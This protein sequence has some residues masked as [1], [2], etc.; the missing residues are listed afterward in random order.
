[1]NNKKSLISMLL[2]FAMVLTPFVGLMPGASAD[3]PPAGAVSTQA[4]LVA[5]IGSGQSVI[6]IMNDIELTDSTHLS[7]TYNVTIQSEAGKKYTVLFKD[8]TRI[9]VSTGAGALTL[10]DIVFIQDI[11]NVRINSDYFSTPFFILQNTARLNLYNTTVESKPT[12]S[13]STG[14][15]AFG[16]S[17]TIYIEG[18]TLLSSQRALYGQSQGSVV[19]IK[20]STVTST[21]AALYRGYF[22][23][24]GGTTYNSQSSD[25]Y[26]Y[27]FRNMSIDG[28]IFPDDVAELKKAGTGIAV[29]NA[30]YKIY[31]MLAPGTFSLSTAQEYT[32]P[33]PIT[34][35][36]KFYVAVGFTQQG[37]T[38]FSTPVEMDFTYMASGSP[39]YAELKYA[40]L[41][42]LTIDGTIYTAESFTVLET[43]LGNAFAL[44]NDPSANDADLVV[45]REAIAAAIL[46]LEYEADTVYAK[47]AEAIQAADDADRIGSYFTTVSFM[48]YTKALEEAKAITSADD[49]DAHKYALLALN[50]AVAALRPA[51]SLPVFVI[52]NPYGTID[53]DTYGQFRSN[54]HTHSNYSDGSGTPATVANTYWNAGYDFLMMADHNWVTYPWSDPGY[55]TPGMI[56]IIGNELSR[57]QHILSLFT[58]FYDTVGHKPG[59]IPTVSPNQGG[60]YSNTDYGVG[61]GNEF[62]ILRAAIVYDDGKGR[63]IIAHPGRTTGDN[64]NGLSPNG[65][66][67]D[68]SRVG[69]LDWYLALFDEFPTLLGMEVINLYDRYPNDRMLWDTL[70]TLS[71]P[72]RP[73]WGFA[74]DD[75]H[76]GAL[77]YAVN[78]VLLPANIKDQGEEAA[79]AA[80]KDALDK[81][82]FFMYSYTTT[83]PNAGKDTGSN[84]A[85]NRNGPVP[86][87]KDIIVD[88]N[89]GTITI[90]AINYD[91][92]EWISKDGIVVGYGETIDLSSPGVDLYVRAVLTVNETTT[93]ACQ[94]FTQ[95]FGL[96][97][98]P[99]TYTVTFEDHDGT[100]LRTETVEEGG[101]ATAPS[102]PVRDGH[103]FIGWNVDFSII[104]GDLTVTAQ[105][106]VNTY[107]ISLNRSGTY[108][109]TGASAGYGAQTAA[110]VTVTNTGNQ[111][112][113]SMTVTLTGTNAADFTLSSGTLGSIAAGGTG[114]F[115]VVPKTGLAA[116]TYTATVTVGGGDVTSQMFT[117]S[118]TVNANTPP[119]LPS[120]DNP[121]GGDDRGGDN[122]LLYVG[123]AVAAIL[124]IIGV[125]WFVLFKP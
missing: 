8:S 49:R 39:D 96:R 68:Q 113:G 105:Y 55:T 87:I 89:G 33:V 3:D 119:T 26:V 18:S 12:L 100:I 62:D 69:S 97:S 45:A 29:N 22:I 27:D 25:A 56:P 103:T 88:E 78:L 93:D 91:K 114:S 122:T 108:T 53:F 106:T 75:N 117:V 31:Y 90:K 7:I 94:T 109:F 115:T 30:N 81:G 15:I 42:A 83:G 125:A 60:N 63:F 5:A 123:I 99:A 77:G 36:T 21:T 44:L 41:A 46:Q 82:A 92:I 64:P 65:L 47:L 121:P 17:N 118:F 86:T 104:T 120:G 111:S 80:F 112:T 10:K 61:Y 34:E 24:E 37:R 74:N 50:A 51:S 6:T 32:S 73:I 76:G 13:G 40:Y 59:D 2:V 67:G 71:M 1:M 14:L 4:E 54:L 19:H 95:P 79:V 57:R 58:D 43:A 102:D 35:D 28:P 107:G 98:V 9:S 70:L 38:Y 110:P 48:A 84:W 20:D 124:G 23:V 16:A 116:G 85:A 11:S 52:D 101:S 66:S 72:D